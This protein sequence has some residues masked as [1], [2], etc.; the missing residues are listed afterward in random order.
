[1]P[2]G[3]ALSSLFNPTTVEKRCSLYV[4]LCVHF[5]FAGVEETRC[6]N[7]QESYDIVL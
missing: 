7:K 2:G 3:S 1:M 6:V 4:C 5:V